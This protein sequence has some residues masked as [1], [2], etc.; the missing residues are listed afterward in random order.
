MAVTENDYLNENDRDASV[1][2]LLILPPVVEPFVLGG[3]ARCCAFDFV[4]GCGFYRGENDG[5]Y[6]D[7]DPPQPYRC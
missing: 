6:R 7:L 3:P 1:T 2:G 4:T 5:A